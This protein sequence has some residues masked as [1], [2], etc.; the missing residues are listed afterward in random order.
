[1]L[2]FGLNQ[3]IPNKKTI[4]AKNDGNQI[5]SI[6]NNAFNSFK[7]LCKEMNKNSSRVNG[8]G[9]TFLLNKCCADFWFFGFMFYPN[10]S[11]VFDVVN[12]FPRFFSHT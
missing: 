11:L 2:I 7:T 6:V 5:S 10:I 4:F 8:F 1:M 3:Q 12:N 9:K